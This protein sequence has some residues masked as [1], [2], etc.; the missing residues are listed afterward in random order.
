MSDLGQARPHISGFRAHCWL[1]DTLWAPR[2]RA[3]GRDGAGCQPGF[4][5]ALEGRGWAWTVRRNPALPGHVTGP[6][7]GAASVT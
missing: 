3:R 1:L 6:A 4:P 7:P 5:G 2:V